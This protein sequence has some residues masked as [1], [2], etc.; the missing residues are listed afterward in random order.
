MEERDDKEH[1]GLF[2]DHIRAVLNLSTGSLILSAT[3]IGAFVAGS[4]TEKLHV[5]GFLKASWVLFVVSIASATLYSY[6]F[7]LSARDGFKPYR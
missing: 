3:L 6:L 4:E 5:L 1:E 2:I 7:A